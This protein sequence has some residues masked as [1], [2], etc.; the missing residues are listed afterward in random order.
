ML[1]MV[2]TRDVVNTKISENET[3]KPELKVPVR[4]W[5]Q[6]KDEDLDK[7]T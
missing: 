3:W 1:W 2:L 6:N 5:S 7:I 4:S